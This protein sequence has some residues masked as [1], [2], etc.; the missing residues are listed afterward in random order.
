MSD[1]SPRVDV[2]PLPGEKPTVEYILSEVRQNRLNEEKNNSRVA[3]ELYLRAHP[4]IRDICD[5][6]VR[7]VLARRR[8]EDTPE[9]VQTFVAGL[10][11]DPALRTNV[12]QRKRCS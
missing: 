3:N 12:E 9:D 5:Y 6:V 10:L 11:S 1:T 2:P 4:E 8:A 7:A